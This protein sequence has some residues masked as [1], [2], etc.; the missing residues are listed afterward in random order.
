M[1]FKNIR[2]S[3]KIPIDAELSVFFWVFFSSAQ[4]LINP[5]QNFF[6]KQHSFQKRKT[7]C[8]NNANFGVSITCLHETNVL[9]TSRLTMRGTIF[10]PNAL[11][12]NKRCTERKVVNHIERRIRKI[13]NSL[14]CT[15]WTPPQRMIV[16][17]N[18]HIG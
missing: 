8:I 17:M 12:K 2:G 7:L 3:I 18:I 9:C 11:T 5:V 14:M 1:S 16:M 10:S 15:K 13:P 4:S 6:W